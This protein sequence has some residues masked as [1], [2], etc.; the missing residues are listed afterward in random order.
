MEEWRDIP[1]L[2]GKYQASTLGRIRSVNLRNN[3]YSLGESEHILKPRKTSK[4]YL[5]IDIRKDGKRHAVFVH[6]LV[7]MTF[8]INPN[9]VRMI[10]VNHKDG[11]KTNNSVDNIEWCD[12]SYN[13]RH[14][15]RI[16]LMKPRK[17]NNS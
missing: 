14:A 8:L 10:Q 15:Y 4:G 17:R 6:R 12:Q 11:N 5:S 1:M 16:G 7:A 2:M 3:Q 9:P 13:M